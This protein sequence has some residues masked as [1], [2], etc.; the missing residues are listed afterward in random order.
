MDERSPL[1]G[2]QEDLS[3]LGAT[4]LLLTQIDVRATAIARP[5]PNRWIAD[6]GIETL[7]LGPDQ[8]LV[9]GAIERREEILRAIRPKIDPHGGSVVDV[10]SMRS[11]IDLPEDVAWNV[12]PSGCGIDLDAAVWRDGMCAQTLLARVPV[13]LQRRER[14]TRVFVR[15]SFSEWLLDWM[16]GVRD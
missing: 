14:S 7:W 15:A 10:S 9:T 4:E 2:R 1:G 3:A 8:S 13:L 6:D 16:L 12:L 5:E 11:V